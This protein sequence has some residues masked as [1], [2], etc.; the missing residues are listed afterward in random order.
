MIRTRNQSQSSIVPR[1]GFFEI[2]PWET[3]RSQVIIEVGPWDLQFQLQPI[4]SWI[5]ASLALLEMLSLSCP[6]VS[7]SKKA[8]DLGKLASC[9]CSWPVTRAAAAPRRRRTPCVCFVA[10]P[11]TQ[12]GMLFPSLFPLLNYSI[13][14][15]LPSALA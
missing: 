15:T 14:I 8:F 13:T 3:N 1:R 7:V 4:S 12:P 10:L 9:R 6:G 11:A 2:G 5:A